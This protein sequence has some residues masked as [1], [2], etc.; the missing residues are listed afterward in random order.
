[1]L[2][3]P[4]SFSPVR[5]LAAAS[6]AEGA[7]A[8][9]SAFIFIAA[10]SSVFLDLLAVAAEPAAVAIAASSAA[11]GA[12]AVV[13]TAAS[14]LAACAAIPVSPCPFPLAVSSKRPPLAFAAVQQSSFFL[15]RSSPAPAYG[16]RP[17]EPALLDSYA[18]FIIVSPEIPTV[19]FAWQGFSRSTARLSKSPP[20]SQASHPGSLRLAVRS[21]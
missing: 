19:A 15:M 10:I 1:M 21:Y 8:G 6:V 5:L 16:S 18:E 2:I 7:F 14:F 12:V 4:S 13:G 20:Y 17:S 3:P 11:A 9:K